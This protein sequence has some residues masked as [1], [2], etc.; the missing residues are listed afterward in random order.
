MRLAGKEVTTPRGG[1]SVRLRISLP[2]PNGGLLIPIAYAKPE[3]DQ[4]LVFDATGVAKAVTRCVFR[5]MLSSSPLIQ[6][7][8]TSSYCRL[9]ANKRD[10]GKRQ[11][12]AARQ[13][14]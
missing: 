9:R 1:L 2:D 5:G 13:L 14:E 3:L 10:R 11:E 7:I 8:P 4:W 12:R 6:S